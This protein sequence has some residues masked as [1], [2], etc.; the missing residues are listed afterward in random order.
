MGGI[1]LNKKYNVYLVSENGKTEVATTSSN[2]L[3]N[4][5]GKL[6]KTVWLKCEETGRFFNMS[7]VLYFQVQEIDN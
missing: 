5:E 2:T 1:I 7:K 4:L 3:P 6:Q